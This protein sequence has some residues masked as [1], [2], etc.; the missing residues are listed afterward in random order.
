MANRKG[1]TICTDPEEARVLERVHRRCKARE[2]RQ[3][4]RVHG[5]SL[6]A[7]ERAGTQLE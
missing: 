2:N 4:M 1:S 3:W 5:G 6:A 7:P